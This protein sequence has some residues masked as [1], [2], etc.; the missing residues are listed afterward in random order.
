MKTALL[1]REKNRVDAP[2]RRLTKSAILKSIKKMAV[3][4]PQNTKPMGDGSAGIPYRMD[5]IETWA[6]AA[7]A[8]AS[9][10][11][12]LYDVAG[13]LNERGYRTEPKVAL[14]AEEQAAIDAVIE[15]RKAEAEAKAAKRAADQQ[16][17][18]QA[19]RIKADPTAA[20]TMSAEDKAA[21]RKLAKEA[22]KAKQQKKQAATEAQHQPEPAPPSGPAQA[23]AP[24]SPS[25]SPLVAQLDLG[26]LS[27]VAARRRGPHPS[28]LS[29]ISQ[30]EPPSA[31]ARPRTALLRPFSQPGRVLAPIETSSPLTPGLRPIPEYGFFPDDPTPPMSP[32]PQRGNQA[33]RS[34]SPS[35]MSGLSRLSA[36][37]VGRV[38]YLTAV[39]SPTVTPQDAPFG[40]SGAKRA[41][42]YPVA[43]TKE[44]TVYAM[45]YDRLE[46]EFRELQYREDT[47]SKQMAKELRDILKGRPTRAYAKSEL[48]GT[49][50]ALFLGEVARSPYMLPI[51][52]MAVDLI[53]VGAQYGSKSR[54]TYTFEKLMSDPNDRTSREGAKHPMVRDGS[55]K[56]AK[57]MFDATI[58]NPV[59]ERSI[60]ITM[61]WLAH[62]LSNDPDWDVAVERDGLRDIR[63][64]FHS[65]KANL[66]QL[67]LSDAPS[68]DDK[69]SS[70]DAESKANKAAGDAPIGKGSE[71]FREKI[72][73]L[74]KERCATLDCLL[75]QGRN[76]AYTLPPAQ[77]ARGSAAPD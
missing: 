75:V 16:K 30:A 74:L 66:E 45:K 13:Q 67:R 27:G 71:D 14:T 35:D 68:G 44:R 34:N 41:R 76:F 51:G 52:L 17:K 18:A 39:R 26:A 25:V 15:K 59:R 12:D 73:S 36:R 77:R 64:G 42:V 3:E 8:P 19:A 69:Q 58:D 29:D 23:A 33:Q 65:K 31:A 4:I 5:S 21:Q 43:D 54:K 70:A 56:L 10:D 2:V 55:S 1:Y 24:A 49:A 53:E 60:G 7:R 72:E 50:A 32:F 11:H 37:S 6:A 62:R 28:P 61:T 9:A 48:P 22:K 57:N 20:P 38:N 40:L 46:N 63:G 47:M